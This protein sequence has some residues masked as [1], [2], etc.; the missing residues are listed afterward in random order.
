MRHPT[1]TT[2]RD[3]EGIRH[4]AALS[5]LLD[6]SIP[7][8]GTRR[9]IGLDAVIGLVP[10]IGDTIGAAMSAYIVLAAA[11]MGVSRTAL[12]RMVSNV[13]VETVVG[14]VPVVGDL[15]DAGWKANARNMDLLRAEMELP[16]SRRRSSRG[17][18]LGIALV[19]L[20]LVAGVAVV[21][22]LVGRLLWSALTGLF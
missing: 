21:A 22:Y 15:F 20:L 9:R 7:I 2:A 3:D 1:P 5:H 4:L 10:G 17:A 19:L 12:M 14:S 18:L 8:P 6:N 11:R 16:G 13:A